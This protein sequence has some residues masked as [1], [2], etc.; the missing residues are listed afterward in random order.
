MRFEIEILDISNFHGNT[1]NYIGRETPWTRIIEHKW[2][3][4]G[5]EPYY[6]INNKKEWLFI[7][8]I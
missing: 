3:E 2:V 1:V 8:A 7:S 5:D 4:S 6:P